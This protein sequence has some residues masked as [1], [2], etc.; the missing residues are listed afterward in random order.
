MAYERS[1]GAASWLLNLDNRN[2]NFLSTMSR[3]GAVFGFD[4]RGGAH[5][6]GGYAAESTRGIP[7]ATGRWWVPGGSNTAGEAGRWGSKTELRTAMRAAP[8]RMGGAK[9]LAKSFGQPIFAAAFAVWDYSTNRAQGMGRLEAGAHVV[10]N[11]AAFG[12]AA[13]FAIPIIANPMTAAIAIPL[14]ATAGALYFRNKFNK[15]TKSFE[16]E[17]RQTEFIGDMSAFNTGAAN[18]MRQ[19]SALTYYGY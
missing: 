5:S 19:R 4:I 17:A 15:F 8:G 6:F 13:R 9:M 16:K 11:Y 12:L 3:P 10:K 1:R 14:A 7:G 18:T 2:T